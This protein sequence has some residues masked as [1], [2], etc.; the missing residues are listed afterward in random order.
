MRRKL[1]W[2]I[3]STLLTFCLLLPT[4]MNTEKFF[5]RFDLTEDKMYRI[6]DVSKKLFEEIDGTLTVTC[7]ASDTLKRVTGIPQEIEDILREYAAYGRGKIRIKTVD[8]KQDEQRREIEGEGIVVR[9]IEVVEENEKTYADIEDDQRD[10]S[11][12]RHEGLFDRCR[13]S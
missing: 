7:Y 1:S 2:E 5:T 11:A 6:S 9:Q 4:A 3:C 12:F 13:Y 10:R 8:P